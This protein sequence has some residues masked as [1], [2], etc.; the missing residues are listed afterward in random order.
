MSSKGG[1]RIK[2]EEA[3]EE[4]GVFKGAKNFEAPIMLLL[5]PFDPSKRKVSR[6]FY[7]REKLS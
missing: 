5:A 4:S 1:T 2:M 3:E 6:S 7:T